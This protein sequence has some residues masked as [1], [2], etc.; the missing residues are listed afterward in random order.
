MSLNDAKMISL[1]GSKIVAIDSG[2]VDANT[3]E[4]LVTGFD[5]IQRENTIV[6]GRGNVTFLNVPKFMRENLHRRTENQVPLEAPQMGGQSAPLR[7][8]LVGAAPED[9]QLFRV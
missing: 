2:R 4:F 7:A 8:P 6:D 3:F 1:V 5:P 9:P